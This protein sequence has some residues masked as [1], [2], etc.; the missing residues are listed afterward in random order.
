MA[1]VFGFGGDNADDINGKPQ[2]VNDDLNN[3]GEGNEPEPD[4]LGDLGNKKEPDNKDTGSNGDNNDNNDDKG[5]DKGDKIDLS[6][7]QVIEIGDDSYTVDKEGN[8]VDK[9]GNIFKEA[10]DVQD[11]LKEFEVDDT[12]SN[13][14]LNIDNIQK[15][16]GIELTDDNDKPIQFENTVEGVKSYV[17]SVIE[18]QKKDI[19]EAAVAA[20]FTKYPVVE[21]F[22]NYYIANGE[23]Y[24][25][26]GQNPDRSNITIDDNNE[27]QQENII[28][29]AWK[30]RNMGGDVE[31]YIQYLKASNILAAT[32]RT[33][34]KALQESDKQKR[35][36]Y[37]KEAKRVE[38]EKAKSLK[39]YWDGVANVITNR[40]IAGYEIPEQILITR[41]GKKLTATPK[42]FFNY[43]YQVD[44]DG[45][46]AYAKDFAKLTP[47]QKRDD[48]ILRA[49][50][51]FTGGTYANLI[52]MA[53]KEEKIKTLKLHAKEQKKTSV[54]MKP[55]T[56]KGNNLDFGF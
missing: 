35:E 29:T 53:I 17:N 39:E 4:D 20:I 15:A 50:L 33:E 3:G 12:D 42:D 31:S 22:I 51:T 37:E 14:E 11:F 13:E 43:V 49:F 6:E 46:S 55:A 5:D 56:K 47:E 26:F 52:D 45:K 18:A 8:L 7:G 25:G 30:E 38:E 48:E 16:L 10:K 19:A 41:D 9:D 21:D 40:K 2:D 24:E 44:K 54:R 28:R 1:D 27:A 32:A 36:E 34:L 23:S